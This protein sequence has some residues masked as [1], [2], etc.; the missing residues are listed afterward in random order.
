MGR[1]WSAPFVVFFFSDDRLI[2]LDKPWKP[3]ETIY[4]GLPQAAETT[5]LSEVAHQMTV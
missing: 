3:T 4:G 1:P 2:A 5:V